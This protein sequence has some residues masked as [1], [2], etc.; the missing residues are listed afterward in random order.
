MTTY[1]LRIA[2]DAFRR[3]EDL[4]VVLRVKATEAL[5][6]LNYLWRWVLTLKEKGAPDG[7][8]KGRAAVLR[9]EA[10]AR[11]DG[12]R[13]KLVEALVELGLITR[14]SKKIRVK[15]TQRYADEYRKREAAR[16]RAKTSRERR[17]S[18][19]PEPESAQSRRI[20]DQPDQIRPKLISIDRNSGTNDAGE[21]LPNNKVGLWTWFMRARTD[22]RRL[23]PDRAMFPEFERWFEAVKR[24]G[25]TDYELSAAWVS[26]LGD[27]H[28]AG[29]R[30]P[31]AV[32][33]TEGVFRPRLVKEIA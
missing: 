22:I 27:E 9:L 19:T 16:Q 4:A 30:W 24:E 33:I 21:P 31:I 20:S 32:F 14:E 28:F 12:V 29:R 17:K 8:V 23:S 6:M 1:E 11:W 18:E 7:I 15:G 3:A 25:I 13:G 5:G 10:A 2:D 26:Y